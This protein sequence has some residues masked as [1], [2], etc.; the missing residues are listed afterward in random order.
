[1][2]QSADF[3]VITTCGFGAVAVVLVAVLRQFFRRPEPTPA[4]TAA[5]PAAYVPCHTTACGHMTTEHDRT[6]AGLTC[7]NCGTTREET[8]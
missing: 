5:E 3:M 6:P 8:L 2:S 1:M 4:S 7:R